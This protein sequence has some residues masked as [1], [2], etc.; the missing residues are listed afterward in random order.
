MNIKRDK[1]GLV[2]DQPRCGALAPEGD[3]LYILLG[4]LNSFCN[5]VSFDFAP[6]LW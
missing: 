4:M 3:S 2:Q 5:K 1:L 6:H